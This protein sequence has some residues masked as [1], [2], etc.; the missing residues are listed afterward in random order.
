MKHVLTY[1]GVV[2]V[3]DFLEEIAREEED[4]SQDGDESGE[5][6]RGEFQYRITVEC[7]RMVATVIAGVCDTVKKNNKS[8]TAPAAASALPCC[9]ASCHR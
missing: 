2:K 7:V 5:E 9:S 4:Q 8:N 6:L 3:L 1:G